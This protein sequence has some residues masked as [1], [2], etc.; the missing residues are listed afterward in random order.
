MKARV[1]AFC[2]GLVALAAAGPGM[3]ARDVVVDIDIA[4]AMF[5]PV[6][7]EAIPDGVKIYFAGQPV[8]IEKIIAPTKSSRRTTR[9]QGGGA[10]ACHKALANV[11]KGMGEQALRNGANAVVNLK[12]NNMNIVTESSTTY[13]CRLG[14]NLVNVALIGDLAVVK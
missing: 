11:L 7:E 10:M 9:G 4:N 12:S 1:A 2:I 3:A 13:K 5:D 14:G 6:V 8:R